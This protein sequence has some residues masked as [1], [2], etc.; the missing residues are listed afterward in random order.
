MTVILMAKLPATAIYFI[1]APTRI[2]KWSRLRAKYPH[3]TH[4]L[5]TALA[6]MGGGVIV[7]PIVR[8]VLFFKVFF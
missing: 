7:L 8:C 5:V 2:P 6:V 3:S 4:K 1:Q